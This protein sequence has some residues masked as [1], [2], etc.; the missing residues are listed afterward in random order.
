MTHLTDRRHHPSAN[1]AP[2][3]GQLFRRTVRPQSDIESP[4]SVEE[5]TEF[6]EDPCPPDPSSLRYEL[7][8][9]LLRTGAQRVVEYTDR[10]MLEREIVT[11]FDAGYGATVTPDGLSHILSQRPLWLN[12]PRVATDALTSV[13]TVDEDGNATALTADE[14]E[15]DTTS[16]PHRLR[17]LYFR[18]Y[19]DRLFNSLRVTY[20]AGKTAGSVPS[21]LRLAVLHFA[22]YMYDRRGMDV[23]RAFTQSGA[24]DLAASFRVPTGL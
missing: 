15:A 12:L 16:E 22:A 8:E 4:V 18:G 3:P 10:E 1:T 21:Q 7:I 23:S 9:T 14:Y 20:M 11:T 19:T 24:L 2:E 6:L 5:F 13:E 17:L